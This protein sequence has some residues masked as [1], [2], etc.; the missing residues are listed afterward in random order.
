MIAIDFDG[1]VANYDG[2]ASKTKFN[3]DLFNLLKPPAE[4]AIITNQ[5]GMVFHEID[6]NRYPSPEQVARRLCEGTRYLEDHGV[7]VRAIYVSCYHPRATRPT[8]IDVSRRLHQLLFGCMPDEAMICTY[9]TAESRK[10][11]PLMLVQAGATVYYGDSD[12][13]EKAA[14]AIVLLLWMERGK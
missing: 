6:P 10:P 7:A 9:T 1:V 5:G 12:E 13:D 11:A 14:A 4:V 8:T 3:P 2:H